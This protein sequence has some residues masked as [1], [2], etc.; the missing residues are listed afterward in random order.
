MVVVVEVMASTLGISSNEVVPAHPRTGGRGTHTAN[1]PNYS[2]ARAPGIHRVHRMAS[3]RWL[4]TGGAVVVAIGLIATAG[5]LVIRDPL[6]IPG[7]HHVQVYA[8]NDEIST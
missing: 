5:F 7:D 6:L 8:L 2:C 3:R 4:M 1:E